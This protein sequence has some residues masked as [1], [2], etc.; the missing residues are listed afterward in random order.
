[1]FWIHPV[2]AGVH[3]LLHVPGTRN[4]IFFYVILHPELEWWCF[5]FYLSHKCLTMTLFVLSRIV[6]T[7]KILIFFSVTV[8]YLFSRRSCSVLQV[9]WHHICVGGDLPEGHKT[10]PQNV[11]HGSVLFL[12]GGFFFFLFLGMCLQVSESESILFCEPQ[13]HASH[14]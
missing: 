14:G 9:G 8:G 10:S 5:F 7:N 11:N 1:M 3:A 6:G 12:W 13:S 4:F 2:I